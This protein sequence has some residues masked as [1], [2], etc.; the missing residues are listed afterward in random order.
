MVRFSADYE[1][2]EVPK[3]WVNDIAMTAVTDF[4]Q[5]SHTFVRI[6]LS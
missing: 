5:P 2:S 3:I 1:L 6:L 4:E